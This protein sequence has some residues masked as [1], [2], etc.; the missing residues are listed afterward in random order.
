MAAKTS[1]TRRPLSA[2]DKAKAD[3]RQAERDALVA[4]L[5]EFDADELTGKALRTFDKLASHY[6]ERNTMLIMIQCPTVTEVKTYKGW[7]AEG[8][9]V[10]KGER[11]IAILAPAGQ[12]RREGDVELPADD[13]PSQ[14]SAD[15]KP[16]RRFFRWITIFDVA[17][18]DAVTDA[19][20]AEPSKTPTLDDFLK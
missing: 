10:R 15:A 9:Q 13:A 12:T 3:A 19:P 4:Q 16:A 8:R 6:S 18:T 1:R 20:A 14:T 2:A 7:Q 11:G 17:Q 5:D